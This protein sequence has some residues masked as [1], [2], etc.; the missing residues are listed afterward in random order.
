MDLQ[1]GPQICAQ[2][3]RYDDGSRVLSA[4]RLHIS[5]NESSKISHLTTE[6][7]DDHQGHETMVYALPSTSRTSPTLAQLR[8]E[9]VSCSAKLFLA[10][11][12]PSS[13]HRYVFDSG[14]MHAQAET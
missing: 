2:D 4:V 10:L 6:K 5:L 11:R 1:I 9:A 8:E 3:P 7:D 12:K 13:P 14:A